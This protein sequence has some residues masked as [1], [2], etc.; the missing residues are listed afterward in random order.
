MGNVLS[1][2]SSVPATHQTPR[3]MEEIQN[4][5][6]E[7]FQVECAVCLTDRLIFKKMHHSWSPETGHYVC[8]DCFWSWKLS[9]SESRADLPNCE[10]LTCP[11]CGIDNCYTLSMSVYV[12]CSGCKTLRKSER[13]MAHGGTHVAEN[14]P[15]CTLCWKCITGAEEC[16]I[17]GLEG[18]LLEPNNFAD[19][20][21]QAQ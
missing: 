21:A 10:Q 13:Y 3:E 18:P 9:C 16:P 6:S 1:S 11:L 15:G 8:L 19:L 7:T 2:L 20:W 12:A 14:H 17:C 4:Q 5:E